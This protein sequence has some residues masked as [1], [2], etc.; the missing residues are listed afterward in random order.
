MNDP[1]S[2]LSLLQEKQRQ[3]E[4][5]RQRTQQ[6]QDKLMRLSKGIINFNHLIKR[7]QKAEDK[8]ASRV[9]RL[10]TRGGQ[11]RD[12]R[13]LL[14]ADKIRFPLVMCTINQNPHKV[15]ALPIT[16]QEKED[17]LLRKKSLRVE[18]ES[19]KPIIVYGDTDLLQLLFDSE[20]DRTAG[21]THSQ[22]VTLD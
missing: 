18:I 4:A 10:S 17:V 1:G 11:A 3:L 15:S 21:K 13:V 22:N 6:K 8:S 20:Q 5:S 16:L 14:S 2:F 19:A 12:G 7:N 9:L